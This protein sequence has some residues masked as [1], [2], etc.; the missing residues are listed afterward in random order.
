[1]RVEIRGIIDYG[2]LNSER[3]VID[4]L[5]DCNIGH[6]MVMHTYYTQHGMPSNK[7]KTIYIFPSQPMKRGDVIVLYTK[8]GKNF[9]MEKGGTMEY[10]FHW[11]EKECIWSDGGDCILMVHY[12]SLYH[13]KISDVITYSKEGMQHKIL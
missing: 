11:G 7:I 13:K 6:Y 3:I 5:E 9:F 12:D 8:E 1:M 10:T 2:N 4:V